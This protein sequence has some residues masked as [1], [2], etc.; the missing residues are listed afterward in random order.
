MACTAASELK[1]RQP[2]N[3]IHGNGS[4]RTFGYHFWLVLSCVLLLLVSSL[5]QSAN[6]QQS[7]ENLLADLPKLSIPDRPLIRPFQT[8][9]L[10]ARAQSD[11]GNQAA[12]LPDPIGRSSTFQAGPTPTAA[13]LALRN[14]N[15]FTN[16]P[17]N[18]GLGRNSESP[19]QN[20]NEIYKPVP[21]DLPAA[22]VARARNTL[23]S[24]N[25]T[26]PAGNR[27]SQ[28]ATPA[29]NTGFQPYVKSPQ[30]A[31]EPKPGESFYDHSLRT[32]DSRAYSV[33]L[34]T[35][36]F[37]A[38]PFYPLAFEPDVEADVYQGKYLNA[39]QRPLLELGRPFYQFGQFPESSTVLGRTNL[40]HP[41][42][43]IFGDYR[44]AVGMNAADGDFNGVLGS[45]LNLE[46]DLRVT[47]TE[48]FHAR[49]AP[50]DR[51][52]QVSRLEFD[53]DG[54]TYINNFDAEF[55]TGFFEG[56]LGALAGGAI[57]EVLPFD[58]PIA[59]GAI[60]LFFQNGITLDDTFIGFAATIA[61]ADNSP[62][63]LI[64]NYDVVFFWGFDNITSSAFQGDDNAAK[65]YGTQFFLE[66]F[67]GYIESHY[68][69]L[70]D[71]NSGNDR[72]YHNMGVSFTRR[73]GH[74][75]SNSIRLIS[76]AGQE[77]VAGGKTADGTL[78][79]LENSFFTQNPTRIIPYLNLFAG[80]G[81]P[82]SIARA[83]NAGGI[84]RNTG[85]TFETDGVTGLPT[86]DASGNNTYGGA[87]G[88]NM[89]GPDF[90]HQLVLETSYLNVRQDA[91]QR[92]ARGEQIGF[93]VRYQ[94]PITNSIIFRTDGI[95]GIRD[96]DT[97]LTGVRFEFR[98]K[99]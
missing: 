10:S 58:L 1:P 39:N 27:A 18:P 71:R 90:S 64:S 93:G 2:V 9:V 15:P 6:G 50:L 79:L 56:D 74:L 92:I 60:P 41:R 96:N 85:I 21:L 32:S 31:E 24:G 89:L 46:F 55:D 86:L 48:R 84:L 63:L 19:V 98:H 94:I 20:Q 97:D 62:K 35:A 22:R 66:M 88:L 7:E 13:T 70:E 83:G 75:L 51:A 54:M 3:L 42:F 11:T 87:L 91:A 37:S 17:L 12:P 8:A 53:S 49:I 99:F 16:E 28:P 43:Q 5:S 14:R 65:M 77:A 23:P 38:D 82:Q 33:P 44:A 95:H 26:L 52:G 80:F 29:P 76:N 67:D 25:N 36:D 30:P 61:L 57:G 73:Y 47:A 68:A 78:L 81:S 4:V 69:Y 72:S 40:V 34:S 45:V 59:V